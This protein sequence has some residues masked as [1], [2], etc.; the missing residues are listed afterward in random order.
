MSGKIQNQVYK[1]AR[2]NAYKRIGSQL[3]SRH[4]YTHARAF[5]T[6][7]EYS[8]FLVCF[9]AMLLLLCLFFKF[10][11]ANYALR[12]LRSSV[13]ICCFVLIK[14]TCAV[15]LGS[16]QPHFFFFI[17]R[18]AN[19]LNALCCIGHGKVC[20]CLWVS[21]SVRE[22]VARALIS[23]F[24]VTIVFLPLAR[25]LYLTRSLLLC[26]V[27]PH[28][29]P[30]SI[31]SAHTLF[32]HSVVAGVPIVYTNSTNCSRCEMSCCSR[33]AFLVAWCWC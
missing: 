8:R 15:L 32:H 23:L 11:I 18:S 12:S 7:F 13:A 3:E 30:L 19:C 9:D 1:L 16:F 28:V 10:C 31:S 20:Q 22:S 27:Q 29:L 21:T 25:C 6:I 17:F 14:S 26:L 4:K 24:I 2:A 33:I 5:T